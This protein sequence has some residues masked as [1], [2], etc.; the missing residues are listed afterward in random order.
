MAARFLF[1]WTSSG[2]GA[3]SALGIRLV[4]RDL[5]YVLRL[6]GYVNSSR[7]SYETSPDGL[8]VRDLVAKI[9]D[10]IHCVFEIVNDE[11]L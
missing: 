8:A 9:H 3:A 5:Q 7:R 11:R 10:T 6:F 4:R 1:N 2:L